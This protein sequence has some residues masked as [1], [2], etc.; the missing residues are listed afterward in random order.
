MPD[1]IEVV[2]LIG[3]SNEMLDSNYTGDRDS[4]PEGTR[5]VYAPIVPDQY[6]WD[7]TAGSEG[8]WRWT[9]PPAPLITVGRFLSRIP[10]DK[11]AGIHTAAQTDMQVAAMLF[12]L[13]G[14]TEGVSLSDPLLAQ[15]MAVMVA[16]S[17]M[18]DDDVAVALEPFTS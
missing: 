8:G 12:M 15:L 5:L 6:T 11:Q 13:Q 9:N 7:P 14:F 16:K 10:L 2:C 1:T 17:L 3:S 18:T 4:L